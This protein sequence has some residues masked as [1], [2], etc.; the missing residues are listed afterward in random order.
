MD[1]VH[2]TAIHALPH[3]LSFP[4]TTPS[5]FSCLWLI[6]YSG[7]VMQSVNIQVKFYPSLLYQNSVVLLN[8]SYQCPG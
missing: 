3:F 1:T 8:W 5:L 6:S 7:L 2:T 4:F